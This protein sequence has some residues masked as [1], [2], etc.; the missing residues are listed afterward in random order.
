MCK[1]GLQCDRIVLLTLEDI[2]TD[3][4]RP[5]RGIKKVHTVWQIL[6][7]CSGFNFLKTCSSISNRL[8][9]TIFLKISDYPELVYNLTDSPNFWRVLFTCNWFRYKTVCVFSSWFSFSCWYSTVKCVSLDVQLSKSYLFCYT[10]KL[11]VT[12]SNYFSV[13]VWQFIL[14]FLQPICT[15]KPVLFCVCF[16]S[17]CVFLVVDTGILIVY[18]PGKPVV[19]L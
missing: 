11:T 9:S 4:R 1:Y 12:F 8:S 3:W 19:A 13:C 10:F 2:K 14:T 16:S 18:V 17:T 7:T 5:V 15:F 6:L